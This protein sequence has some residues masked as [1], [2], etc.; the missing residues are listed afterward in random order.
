MRKPS[1]D[2]IREDR[3]H[4]EAIVDTYGPEEQAMGWYCYLEEKLHF[5]FRGKC[6]AQR[7]TSPLRKGQEVQVIDLVLWGVIS[8][9]YSL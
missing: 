9:T 6:I 1:K 4:N 2:K 5:P 3:I 8:V 7:A